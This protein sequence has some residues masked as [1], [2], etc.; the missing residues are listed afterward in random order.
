MTELIAAVAPFAALLTHYLVQ[1]SKN[2]IARQVA[3]M[4]LAKMT[5]DFQK[6]SQKN[7]GTIPGSGSS[8]TGSSGG[9]GGSPVA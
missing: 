4:L 2:K 7:V 1:F 3:K 5:A 9:S 6:A 8:G